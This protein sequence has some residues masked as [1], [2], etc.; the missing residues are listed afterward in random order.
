LV[1]SQKTNVA[2]EP[3]LSDARVDAR[4]PLPPVTLALLR[5]DLALHRIRAPE[6][7]HAGLVQQ[8]SA[9]PIEEQRGPDEYQER[10][11]DRGQAPRGTALG[12]A[13]CVGWCFDLLLE[14]GEELALEVQRASRR[15]AAVRADRRVAQK[16]GLSTSRIDVELAAEA[17]TVQKGLLPAAKGRL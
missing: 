6:S 17:S 8:R 4:Q 14:C 13:G 5:H 16:P 3:V 7:V 9:P 10:D 1:T 11:G 12:V 15:E 2:K